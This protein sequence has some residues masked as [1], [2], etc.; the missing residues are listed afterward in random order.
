MSAPLV[1]PQGRSDSSAAE[2]VTLLHPDASELS[3]RATSFP[4]P[5]DL[6]RQS[7]QRL[8]VLALLYAFMFFMAGIFPQLLTSGG[9]TDLVGSFM[10]WV[11]SAISIAM[12]LLVAAVVRNPRVP[13]G[14]VM[15]I[16]LAFEVIGS[17][18]IA[19]A[20]FADPDTL[21]YRGDFFGLSWVAVWVLLFTVVIPTRPRHA[22]LAA[23]VSVSAVPVIIGVEL[24]AFPTPFTPNG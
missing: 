6:V 13:L 7:A 19:T 22:V 9:R 24:I 4:L 21:N 15:T 3:G 14:T 10:A 23:L 8:L 20:E 17:Y 12:A 18:G 11:P 16:G 5:S 2:P 1:R